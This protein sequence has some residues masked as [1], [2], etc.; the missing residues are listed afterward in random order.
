MK[1]ITCTL[2]LL[3]VMLTWSTAEALPL[4]PDEPEAKSQPKKT[5][6]AKKKRPARL[7]RRKE[8]SYGRAM[9]RNELL[10]EP[11]ATPDEQ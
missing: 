10:R 11:A 6:K 9:R 7:G 3:A 5:V 1:S 4:R 2:L 8:S